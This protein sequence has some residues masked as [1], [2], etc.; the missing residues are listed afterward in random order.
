MTI[1]SWGENTLQRRDLLQNS[2]Q[3]LEPDKFKCK[4]RHRQAIYHMSKLLRDNWSY[5]PVFWQK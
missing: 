5:S 4:I 2:R 3:K 1:P